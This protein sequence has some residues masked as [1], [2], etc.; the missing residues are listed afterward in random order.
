MS[1]EISL[2]DEVS[3]AAAG[4]KLALPQ[5]ASECGMEEAWDL[6]LLRGPDTDL[7][8]VQTVSAYP[9]ARTDFTRG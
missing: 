4:E 6:G 2:K 1:N 8:G 5:N 7:R 9:L 3:K